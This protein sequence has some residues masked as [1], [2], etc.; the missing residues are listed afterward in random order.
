VQAAEVQM[1]SDGKFVYVSNRGTAND[2]S[3]FET[4]KEGDLSLIQQISTGGKTPRNFNI[5]LNGRYLV[6]ANQESDEIR[7]FKRDVF[8]G[9]LALTE[10]TMK[11]NK[12]VYVLPLQ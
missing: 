2:I 12:P 5:S 9:R 6:V 4:S 11:I 10:A 7:I 8:T 1:S 3:V